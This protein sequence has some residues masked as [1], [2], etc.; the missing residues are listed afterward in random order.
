MI[1][2]S[3]NEAGIKAQEKDS[4]HWD[5]I[6]SAKHGLFDLHLKD[7][8]EYR[9]LIKMFIKRDFVIAY[10]QTILGPLWYLVQP[11]VSSLMYAFV[12]GTLAGV[13]TDGVPFIL[14]YFSG[15]MLWSYFTSCLSGSAGTFLSNQIIFG[16]VYFPRLTAPIATCGFHMIKLIIQFVLLV[17]FMLYYMFVKNIHLDV[18]LLC[19]TF[20]L[21]FIWIGI[22]GTS[23]GLIISS[24]TTKYRDLNILLN[25]AL[26]LAMYATPVVYPLSQ[27][28]TI[29]F[30]FAEL[31]PYINPMCAP[32]EFFR[33]A[34]FGAGTLTPAVVYSSLALTAAFVFFGLVLFTRNERNFVDVI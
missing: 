17:A 15:T 34:F 20:P 1:L 4:E 26:Q 7:V 23:L 18:S 21:I 22:L 16:K 29:P 27:L 24:L 9:Y 11:V 2:M 33:L 6:I 14:F 28:N 19:L 10:K 3:T 12:F 25:F 30:G 32:I 5:K 8:W 13:G 31:I